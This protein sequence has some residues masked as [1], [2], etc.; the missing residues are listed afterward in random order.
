MSLAKP[1][2][3]GA[4]LSTIIVN[5]NTATLLPKMMD[6]LRL[7]SSGLKVQTIIVDNASADGSVAQIR[8]QFPEALLIANQQ[9]VGFGR[10]NNQALPL[11]TGRYVLLLNTDAF[12]SA[13]TLTKTV[14]YMDA[15]PG[16]GILGVRLTGQDGTL[17]P[18][19]RFFPTPWNQFLERTGLD[20]VFKN[21]RMVDDTNWDHVSVR[22][23]DWVPGCYYLVRKAVI[24]QVGL[25]DPRYFL[26][27]EEVDH[28]FAAKNAGWEVVCYPDTT[29]VH[30]GGESAKTVSAITA[31]GRQIEVLR[32][33]SELLYFRKNIGIAGLWLDVVLTSL[34]DAIIVFKHL[35]KGNLPVS[36]GA[37]LNHVAD[38]WFLCWRTRFGTRPTR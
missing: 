35:K 29:V 8:R 36:F 22:H 12:V 27:F 3:S 33:E 34:A 11:A 13:D 31:T 24:D 28:C 10:A 38:V 7:A 32:I 2:A 14:A 23:C 1:A 15:H 25:F 16:C 26:Y 19:A 17:Q 20:R 9:N 6:A 37:Y 5:Y 18:S 30:T 21:V 4:D